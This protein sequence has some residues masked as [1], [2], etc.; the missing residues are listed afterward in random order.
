MSGFGNKPGGATTCIADFVNLRSL[1]GRLVLP[2]IVPLLV[3]M[4][5]AVCA[6]G[7]PSAEEIPIHRCDGLPVLKVQVDGAEKRFLLDTA[8][9]TTLNSKSFSSGRSRPVPVTTWTG[10]T[11]V[12]GREISLKEI[13]VGE[14]RLADLKLPAVD[15]SVIQEA[16]RGPIDGILGF[17]LLEQLGMRI[18]LKRE[19]VLVDLSPGE[20]QTEA[21]EMEEAMH[22]C[23]D[24]FSLGN[25]DVLKDC[26]DPG[27]VLYTPSGEF[28]GR[29]QVMDYLEQHY[30]KFAPNVRFETTLR[31]TR[32]LGDAVWAAY[33]YTIESPNGRASGHGNALCLRMGGRWRILNMHNSLLQPELKPVP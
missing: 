3:C 24:A 14:H 20:L 27:I 15:L 29:R 31:D 6:Q 25:A 22:R 30:L 9:T 8:S 32:I 13:A 18:D 11:V 19:V 33:D 23:N 1:V 26:L 10:N 7:T 5:A 17:D 16:C 21:A 2:V 4:P 12:S 28:R